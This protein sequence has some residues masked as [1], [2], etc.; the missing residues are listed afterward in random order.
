MK[1]E[2]LKENEI[3][4]KILEQNIPNKTWKFRIWGAPLKN[5]ELFIN[6]CFDKSRNLAICSFPN[7][8]FSFE[9]FKNIEEILIQNPSLET[10]KELF[11]EINILPMIKELYKFCANKLNSN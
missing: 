8:N 10:P 4:F 1:I 7:F 5:K 11:S 9:I 6:I 2:T 3:S